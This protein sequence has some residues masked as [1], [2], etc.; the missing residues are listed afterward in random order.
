M[1]FIVPRFLHNEA[2]YHIH[3]SL[4]GG[5]LGQKKTIEKAL[6]RFYWSSIRGHCNNWV[7]KC[8]E[9]SKVEHP[10]RKPHA[11]LGELPVD[12]PLDR[13]FTDILGPFPE[14]T[15]GNKYV[16]A[17]SDYFTKWVE[18]FAIPDQSAAMCAEIILNKVIAWFGCPYDTHSDQGCNYESALFSK[19]CQLLEMHKTRTTPGHLCCNGQVECFNRTLV[20]MIKSYLRGQQHNWDQHIG[21]LAAA[22]WATPHESTGM[23]PNLLMFG[24][25][26]RMPIEVMLGPSR[27]LTDEEVTSY[28]DYVETLREQM[29]RAHDVAWK[30][31][32]RSAICT[33]E[34]YDAKC[35]LTKYK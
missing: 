5:H 30:H 28:G 10:P 25:E 4:L 34:Y 13:I 14:S 3:D 33:K 23:T 35:T 18:I 1:Q 2:L 21:C 11:P 29:Q 9:C 8:N 12:A 24:R 26:V 19:L 7:S 32:G 27:A 31:V 17:V 6:Q 16:L 20:G 15:Q 22:Y